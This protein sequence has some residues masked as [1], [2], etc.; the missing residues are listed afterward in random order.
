MKVEGGVDLV[1][2]IVVDDDASETSNGSVDV[3]DDASGR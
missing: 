1:V 2:H 3:V